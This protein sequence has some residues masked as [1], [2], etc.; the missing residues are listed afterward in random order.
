M[1]ATAHAIRREQMTGLQLIPSEVRASHL[2]SC[3][4]APD[5]AQL[6]RN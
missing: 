4:Q 6:L 2:L 1:V 5:F 3:A